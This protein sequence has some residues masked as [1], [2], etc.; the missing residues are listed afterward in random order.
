MIFFRYLA[1]YSGKDG[2]IENEISAVIDSAV[3][4]FKAFEKKYG[5]Q[6]Y[7]A[8]TKYIN[9]MSAVWF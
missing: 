8:Q 9:Q 1:S 7:I 2:T 5:D 4:A 6:H 3:A